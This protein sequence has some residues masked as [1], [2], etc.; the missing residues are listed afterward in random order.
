MNF[1]DLFSKK[2]VNVTAIEI[3]ANKAI[4]ESQNGNIGAER[5]ALINLFNEVQKSSSQLL[6]V[7]NLNVVGSAYF[8]MADHSCFTNNEDYRRVIAD[9]T[10][11]CL[12][13][14]I[15]NNK[16][17]SILRLKRLAMLSVF[18]KDF[19]YTIAN[20]M[21]IPDNDFLNPTPLIVKTNSYYYCIAKHDFSILN[22]SHFDVDKIQE[23]YVL[24]NKNSR[25]DP[26][27]GLEY[28]E[29]ILCYLEGVYK[30]Y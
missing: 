4:I 17:N 21:E 11:Y 5:E 26:N 23:L 15:E 16:N 13:K 2:S 24:A 28:I 1:S 18:H 7:T 12:S 19:Y 10:F 6:S 20:A 29:K 3:F 14:A 22:Q 9:N 25:Y 8:L 30:G 27:K